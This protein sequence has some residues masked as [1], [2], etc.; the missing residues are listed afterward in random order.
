[1]RVL[2][3]THAERTHLMGLVPLGWAFRARGDDVLVATQPALAETAHAAGLPVVPVGRDTQLWRVARALGSADRIPPLGH[4]REPTWDFLRTELERVVPWWWRMVNDPMIDDLVTLCRR[5]RPDLVLWGAVT[6]AG[7]LAAH[8]TGAQ[9]A[10]V[11]FGADLGAQL[12]TRYLRAR[13]T[14]CTDDPL[15][16]WLDRVANRHGGSADAVLVRGQATVDYLPPSLQVD[17]D[18]D[19][20]GAPGLPMRFVPFHGRGVVPAWLRRPP[21]APRVCVTLGHSAFERTWQDVETLRDVVLGAAAATGPGNEVVVT[22]PNDLR[23]QL[24]SMPPRVRLTSF[25]PLD[26]LAPSCSIVISHGGGGTLCTVARHGVPQLVLPRSYDAPVLGE[27]IEQCGAGRSLDPDSATSDSVT[28][29]LLDLAALPE[30]VEGAMRLKHELAAM[31][32]PSKVADLL[33]GW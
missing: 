11:L 27:A 22:V 2:I 10:R 4:S 5:W 14:G 31:P 25:V 29:A 6:F 20:D 7:G 26:A 28:K 17:G 23:A 9:H 13:P 21:P 16:E 19:E 15:L 18:P 33:A 12:Y 3:V 1:M 32:S 8:L 30:V 24:G